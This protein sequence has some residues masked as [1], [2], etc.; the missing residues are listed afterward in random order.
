MKIDLPKHLGQM[1]E[2]IISLICPVE[3]GHGDDRGWS[4]IKIIIDNKTVHDKCCIT[5]EGDPRSLKLVKIIKKGEGDEQ[6]GKE[7]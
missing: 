4:F 5:I 1:D 7:R 2:E 3:N 6:K